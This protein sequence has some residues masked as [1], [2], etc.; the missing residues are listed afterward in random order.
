MIARH[1]LIPAAASLPGWLLATLL[2]AP[3]LGWPLAVAG[4]GL[5]VAL[6]AHGPEVRSG[7]VVSSEHGWQTLER[8]VARARRHADCLTLVRIGESE[9]GDLDIDALT[10]RVRE[11]DL[12]WRDSAI[13]L[14][15][16]GAGDLG[17]QALLGRLRQ[18]FPTLGAEVSLRSMTFPTD[19]LTVH[20]LVAGL[21]SAEPR[22]VR[23][24]SRVPASDELALGQELT[25]AGGN[26]A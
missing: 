22:P 11:V 24:P 14:V 21:S 5:A 15:A 2:D 26:G 20:A 13:W 17:A 9:S 25:N 1:L 19:A 4:V 8:E 18:A 6:G 7:A 12:A 16:P 23:L 3:V 10:D